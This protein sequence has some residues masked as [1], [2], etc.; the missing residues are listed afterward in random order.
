MPARMRWSLCRLQ[1]RSGGLA[2][3]CYKLIRDTLTFDQRIHP[4]ALD[5]GN[6]DEHVLTAIARLD[7]AVA[8]HLVEPFHG[9]DSHLG[10]LRC[11]R[12]VPGAEPCDLPRTRRAAADNLSFWG[13]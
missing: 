9:T 7:E 4:R 12:H 3:L 5:R 2:A 6:M 8:L 13:D 1:V 10:L 11:R